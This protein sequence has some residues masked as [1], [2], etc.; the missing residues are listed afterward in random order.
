MPKATT[1]QGVTVDE[2]REDQPLSS[3][4]LLRRAREG[5]GE[6]DS[7][8]EQPADFQIESYPPPVTEDPIIEPEVPDTFAAPP[9]PVDI[10]ASP[11]PPTY[12][13]T[14]DSDPSTWAPPAAEPDDAWQGAAEDDGDAWRATT[15]GP[16][17]DEVRKSG[18][19]FMSKLWIVVVLVVGGFALFSFLDGSKTVDEI[20][21]GDCLNTPE[22]DV[23]FEIDPIDCTEPHDLEVF[24]LVD[25]S[26]V[27]PDFAIA[28][29]YPGDELVYESAIDEC[30]DEFERYVGIPYEDSV[31]Y[32]DAFTPTLEGWQEVDDRIAN[33]VLFEVNA[34]QT[35]IV[36][37]R[38]SLRG[39]GR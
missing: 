7:S 13:S 21:V 22:D 8:P 4:E 33:C 16:A 37:S 15:P 6:G 23:F 11:E 29:S 39:S 32:M 12:E 34:D 36:Q 27:S 14:P 38:T 30:Y 9:P 19:G 28:A 5:L 26:S 24:A 25:L 17:P 20:A 2:N 31:L 35:D 18:G 10:P 3:E 1:Y